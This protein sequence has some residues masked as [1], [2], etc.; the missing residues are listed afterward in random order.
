M[1]QCAAKIDVVFDYDKG[2]DFK[3]YKT[4]ARLTDNVPVNVDDDLVILGLA[5]DEL[6]AL[7]DADMQKKGFILDKENP[8][9][10][11]SKSKIE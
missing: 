8:W 2:Q 3:Q 6:Y 1:P 11:S 4:Y 10:F 5:G 7:I 9:R